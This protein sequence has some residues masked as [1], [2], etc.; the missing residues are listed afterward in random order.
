MTMETMEKLK[1]TNLWQ[2]PTIL[3]MVDR[4]TIKPEGILED[5]VISVDS[6]EYPVSGN[7]YA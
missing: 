7:L 6:W 2:T 1:S 4:S 3:Q 5:V